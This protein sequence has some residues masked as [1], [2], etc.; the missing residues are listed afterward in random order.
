MANTD[1][2]NMTLKDMEEYT[3]GGKRFVRG[4]ARNISIKYK[5]ASITMLVALI[6]MVVLTVLMLIFYNRAIMQR[7]DKQIEENI[8]IMSDRISSVL[9]NGELCSNN[10]TIEFGNYYNDKTMKQVTRDN[11]I[12]SQLSQSLLIYNG[13]SSIVFIDYSGRF[14]SSDPSFSEDKAHIKFSE[15]VYDL[16]YAGGKT[17]MMDPA[18]NPFDKKGKEI[19][20]LGKHVINIVTGTHLGYLFVNMDKD[21]LIESSQSEIS[22]YFLY[23]SWGNILSETNIKDP[24]YED[25]DFIEGLLQSGEKLIKYQNETYLLA[26]DAIEEYD[27]TVIGITNL[28][29]FNVTGKDLKFILLTTS[30]F[31]IVLLLISV[32]FSANFV[33]KPLKVLHDG[34]EQIAEGDMSVRFRFKT[35][36]EIGRLGRIFNYMTQRNMEL[37]KQVDDEAKKKREY[38]LALIQEQVKPHFLY[39]TLDIIIMLIEMNRSKEAARVTHKLA[40]YYKNSLSGSEEIVTIE[41]E[42]QI[43]RDYLDL[44]TMRY[45]DKFSYEIDVDAKAF[46]SQ[47]PKMTLQ[48]LVENAIYHGIKNK[49]SWGKI[50]VTGRIVDSYVELRVIDDGI[51]M[52]VDELRKLND[53]L[54]KE[55]IF[56]SDEKKMAK[57]A[58][59]TDHDST[60][61]GSHFGLYSVAK[62]IKLYFGREYGA[63]IES[64][65]NVGT[66]VI[67]KVPY[68]E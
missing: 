13:I 55:D 19:I 57:E 59:I 32:W 25:H 38:E 44:Q 10:L 16:K 29:K 14:Y 30:S 28:N 24:I 66:T 65:E 21:Y 23:D 36:D 43:I 7:A 1:F 60:K 51:G 49:S 15:Y 62:R 41:R 18:Q 39:N 17:V 64:T 54:N 47:I 34:A 53:L 42:I 9:Q 46:N 5:M 56:D 35:K 27:F 50:T 26:R 12:I 48:P 67:V 3:P 6:P 22:Y 8:R 63:R 33:T 52:K 40:S 58:E 4:R 61:G 31:T 68:S 11:K 45:G 2:N 20:T 37:L